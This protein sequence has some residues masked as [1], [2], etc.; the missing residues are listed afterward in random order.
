MIKLFL[1]TSLRWHSDL[2]V[3]YPR[4]DFVEVLSLLC[5]VIMLI[6]KMNTKKTIIKH[7]GH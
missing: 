3:A 5:T 2:V 4:V 6:N 1:F 7:L